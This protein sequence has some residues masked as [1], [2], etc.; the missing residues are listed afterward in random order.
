MPVVP[1]V[2]QLG[3]ASG[4]LIQ[5]SWCFKT[6]LPTLAGVSSFHALS[7]ATTYVTSDSGNS[8]KGTSG[9]SFNFAF[10]T[11]G[12]YKAF[13]YTVSGLPASLSFN[14]DANGPMITGTL[15]SAGSYSI[16]IVGHR[17]AG[18]NGNQT[19][20]YN[21]SIEV[22]EAN[23]ERSNDQTSSSSGSQGSS[24]EN[25]GALSP[26]NDTNTQSLS[27]GWSRS[28]W[29]GDF[30]GNGQGWVYHFN[31]GWLYLEGVDESGFW[32]YDETL[33]W[34]YTGKDLY[35]FFYRNSSSSWL[36]DQSS[37][38]GRKFWD[39]AGNGVVTPSKN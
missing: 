21:L 19:L 33:G 23:E 35:P 17:Y 4:V 38:S 3:A 30:F 14:E 16:S 13:S 2:K 8:L 36:Y 31:H 11:G 27:A 5:K 32:V 18:Q 25:S 39:Y 7:G 12:N 37:S 28:S 9:E 6:I 15:P 22:A 26:W 29:F 1:L 20:P 24:T 34:L 10:M